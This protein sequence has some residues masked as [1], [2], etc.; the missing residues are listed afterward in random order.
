MQKFGHIPTDPDIFKSY[1]AVGNFVD[2]RLAALE[3][4][5]DYVRGMV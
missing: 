4:L 3:A 1:A 2:V 5:A